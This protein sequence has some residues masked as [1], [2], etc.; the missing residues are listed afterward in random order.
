MLEKFCSCLWLFSQ[1]CVIWC[2]FRCAIKKRRNN[3]NTTAER[4]EDFVLNILLRICQTTN[5]ELYKEI[6]P[7]KIKHL[8]SFCAFFRVR[9]FVDFL[10]FYSLG[11]R[12]RRKNAVE[13]FW[14]L[15]ISILF[16]V[17]RWDIKRISRLE[18]KIALKKSTLFS[19]KVH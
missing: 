6:V 15:C 5:I 3:N 19:S 17:S 10:P 7:N 14:K 12:K 16:H 13:S 8:I 11:R 4:I 18:Y 2:E 1:S 9:S